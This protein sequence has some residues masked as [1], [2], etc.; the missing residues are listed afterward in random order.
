MNPISMGG[1]GTM[2]GA[3]IGVEREG[4]KDKWMVASSPYYASD[5]DP[6]VILFHGTSDNV[7]NIEQSQE[8][9]D[10]LKH[11]NVVT[12]FVKV[13]GGS[14][15]GDKMNSTENLNK[16]VAFLDKAR[17][18]KKAA[19]KPAD[20]T[21][22]AD[23]SKK[24]TVVADTSKKDTTV[25]DSTAK[26]STLALPL[27]SGRSFGVE[28]HRNRLLV[29]GESE[30][31]RYTIVSVNGSRKF[32][33]VFR[34]ELDLSALPVGMYGIKVKSSSGVTNIIRFVRK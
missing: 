21:A 11:H 23:T 5:D 14:H 2:E 4:N 6:P 29:R 10:S 22:V 28:I 33:G 26:D 12:E 13:S 15:G 17:E 16:A 9:Y 1:S 18:A 25:K 30:A 24:D 34:K 7:V 32:S 27:L 19:V 3:F 20:S 31:F 8:L